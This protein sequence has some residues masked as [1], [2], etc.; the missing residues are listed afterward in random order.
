MRRFILLVVGCIGCGGSSVATVSGEVLVDGKPLT[1][2]LIEF[3]ALEGAGDP[4][5]SEVINGRYDVTTTPGKKQVKISAPVVTRRH[6]PSPGAPVSEVTEESLPDRYHSQSV[7]T[8][9]VRPGSN[10]K[11]WEVESKKKS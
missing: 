9:D 2:G 6:Q 4:A 1:K 8:L 3:V 10:T 5:R 11:K 7:L